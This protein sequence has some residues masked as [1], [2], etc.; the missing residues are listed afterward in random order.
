SLY[1]LN[2]FYSIRYFNL[3][4]IILQNLLLFLIIFLSRILLQKIYFHN[5]KAKKN[6]NVIIFGAGSYGVNLYQ[7]LKHDNEFNCIGFV[8]E[9]NNKIGRYA[10]DLK[11]FSIQDIILLSK[12]DKIQKCYL[13]IPSASSFKIRQISNIF[14]K[15]DIEIIQTKNDE[16]NYKLPNEI[17]KFDKMN[18]VD[19]VDIEFKNKTALVTGAAGSIGQEICFQLNTLNIEKIYCM[20]SNE[21]SLASLKKKAQTLNIKNFE[22]ILLDL[23]NKELL[24]NFFE[25]NK[26]DIIFH[27]AAHKHVDIVEENI[28]YSCKNNLLS[29]LNILNLSNIFDVNNFIFISTDKAVRPSNVMGLTKRCGE[30]LTYFYSQKNSNKNYSSVRFG[31]VIGSSGS[32][33]EIL[34]R[35]ISNGGPITLTDK[36]ASR[37]FMTI[38]DAV[39][40]VLKGAALKINGKILVL[41]MGNSINIYDLIK[42]F[43]K[44]NK[45]TEK[46]LQNKDGDIEVK[47]IGLRKGEKLHE[48]LFYSENYI[49]QDKMIF[50]ESIDEKYRNINIL[51]FEK[52]LK[53]KIIN[54]SES[55]IQSFLKDFANLK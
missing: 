31:N 27:A 10:D 34:K 6:I 29:I 3:N 33:L 37:F 20:D 42:S 22:F 9:D 19:F 47:L 36:R 32:L 44:E 12:R 45:L 54:N 53:E 43:L 46:N 38:S 50:S 18:L 48:E 55:D 23:T 21:Y 5:F 30:I 14:K 24:T 26:I 8:D 51:E 40:L 28:T 49:K 7:N 2:Y 41:N 1:L 15:N 4:F 13:C 35:Q 11:I 39:S 52:N 16:N 25:K 17:N